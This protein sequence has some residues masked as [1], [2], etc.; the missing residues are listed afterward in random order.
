MTDFNFDAHR[1]SAIE[2]YKI[3][4]P[5]YEKFAEAAKQ[6]LSHAL[7]RRNISYHK[8]EAR[9]KEIDSFGAKAAKPMESDLTKPKYSD[10]LKQIEDLAGVRVITF[11]QRAVD[12]VSEC[13]ESEF[14]CL[15]KE[16]KS[17]KLMDD[18]K[19]GYQSVHYIV[20]LLPNR[21]ELPEYQDFKDLKL[22][23]Q[24]RTILQHAWAEVE[25]DL[26]YKNEKISPPLIRRRFIILAGLLEIAD[27]EFQTLYDDDKGIT[28][29]VQ[30]KHP[31]MLDLEVNPLNLG[32]Y[33]RKVFPEREHSEPKYVS[34]IVNELVKENCKYLKDVE[35]LIKK[36]PLETYV[37]P[38]DV[39]S[40]IISTDVG[41]IRS[42]LGAKKIDEINDVIKSWRPLPLRPENLQ[43]QEPFVNIGGRIA[44]YLI[45]SGDNIK[46]LAA[47]A[48]VL[49]ITNEELG[50]R[51][52]TGLPYLR[53]LKERLDPFHKYM[54]SK[55]DI[56]ERG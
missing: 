23:L 28:Q 55:A 25:H 48:G 45:K 40:E 29:Q 21:I 22:E 20:Q 53:L 8:I 18:D 33:L 46:I 50:N 35:S 11:I 43:D 41:V 27:R 9:A 3:I 14:R 38:L 7:E 24:V 16:D 34:E 30:E 17:A 2:Q 26:Q 52:G 13:I 31:I 54:L 44:S 10:P 1:T 36:Y 37:L 15:D 47:N 4:H 56:H 12:E 5:T 6:I 39:E 42:L 19:F 49:E 51:I 32:S